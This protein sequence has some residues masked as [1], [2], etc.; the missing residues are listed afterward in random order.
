M[1]DHFFSDEFIVGNAGPLFPACWTMS[2]TIVGEG[3]APATARPLWARPDCKAAAQAFE[4]A[5][6]SVSPEFDKSTEDGTAYRI[7]RLGSIEVRTSQD[8]DEQEVIGAVF[9]THAQVQGAD[10]TPKV[11]DTERIIR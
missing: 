5:L 9:S 2:P 11:Q 7:Y 6:K 3:V 8:H 4:H 10:V 1:G